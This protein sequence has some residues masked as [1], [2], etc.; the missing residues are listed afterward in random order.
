MSGNA[1]KDY[2]I[3]LATHKDYLRTRDLLKALFPKIAAAG[4]TQFFESGYLWQTNNNKNDLDFVVELDKQ[5]VIKIV[6]SHPTIFQTYRKFGNTVST[7]FRVGNRL[8]HVDLMPTVNVENEAWIMSGGSTAIKGILRNLLLCFLA[9]VKSD[10]LS[11]SSGH[12]V[13]WTIAFP[14]GIG[15]RH[16]GLCLERETSP[17]FILGYL[18][19]EATSHQIELSRTFEGLSSLVS[20]DDDMQSIEKFKE[21]AKEQWLFKKSPGIFEDAFDYLEKTHA[22]N[23]PVCYNITV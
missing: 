8:I 12:E 17:S 1:F 22:T 7:L 10:M 15:Q 4:S 5:S 19:I 2:D 21:Y 11:A 3:S 18:G 6:E 23:K 13:K 9:R 16:N 20:W 14:G